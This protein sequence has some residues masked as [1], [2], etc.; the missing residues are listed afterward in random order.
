M[1]EPAKAQMADVAHSREVAEAARESD[2][3]G[4]GFLRDLF[5]G[6]FHF[7]LIHP[8]P[9]QELVAERPEF[10]RFEQEFER[11]LA[12]KVDSDAIDEDG[13]YPPALVD[14]LRRMGAFGMKVPREYGGLGFSQV[15]YGRIMQLLGSRDGNLA[16]LLSAHQS[17]GVP[18]PLELFGS[19]ELKR[20][21]LPRCARGSI[22][23]FALTEVAAGSDPARLATTAE[24]SQDGTRYVLNG[25]KLWCTNGTLAELLVVLARDPKSGAIS[26]FVVETDWPGVEVVHRSR[27]MGLR[28]LA[29]AALRFDHV[30]VPRENLIGEEGRGLKIA[31]TT[32]NAGRLSIPAALVGT[33]KVA[34]ELDRK[35]ASVRPQ[36]GTEI[37]RHEA[38][39]HKLADIA[40]T[41]YAMESV[42][43]LAQALADRK[44]YDIRLEAAAA[45]AW[46]AVQAWRICDETMQIRG[47]RG[48][49]TKSSL[50][51]RGEA[52][53]GAE[54][55]LR[56]VRGN[57]ILEGSS[58]IMHLFMAREALQVH[59]QVLGVLAD[60][61][62]PMARKAG[63]LPAIARFYLG[64]VLELWLRGLASPFRYRG[65]GRL[66]RHL[67]FVDRASRKLA[68]Q[69]FHGMIVH[70][71][72]LERKQAFLFRLIDV[73]VELLAISAAVSRAATSS[74]TGGRGAAQG[75]HL[76]ERFAVASASRV[77]RLFRGLWHNSD[78]ADYELGRAVLSGE[79]AWL[80]EGAV[81]LGLTDDDLAPRPPTAPAKGARERKAAPAEVA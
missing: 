72:K 6:R 3:Q 17:I 59:L 45:K 23:G 40:S 10:K 36:W 12:E 11:F 69:T 71:P 47:G 50:E 77:K 62:A 9:L 22:S 39:A 30:Q 27:F 60:P 53:V 14:E 44:G 41:T 57:L 8:Y 33:A 46:N 54:R 73:A 65:L 26:A 32:L 48:Y 13:D 29:S 21:Y 67:R 43:D 4:K 34:L 68:R 49:E 52:G 2:W 70:G 63:A 31:L 64:W 61:K 38:I 79:H 5:L 19:E 80:E 66:G 55:W 25:S 74:R 1:N 56:D 28:A 78:R 81:G 18:R 76:A 37:G 7:G 35:W 75:N 42:S 51:A 58:E 20:R 15:E 24:L 16:A